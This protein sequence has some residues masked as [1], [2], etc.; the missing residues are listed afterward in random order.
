MLVTASYVTLFALFLYFYIHAAYTEMKPICIIRLLELITGFPLVRENIIF[1]RPGKSQFCSS[2]EREL[3]KVRLGKGGTQEQPLDRHSTGR[4]SFKCYYAA[5]SLSCAGIQRMKSVSFHC[6]AAFNLVGEMR[7]IPPF[8]QQWHVQ[9]GGPT[10][11][12]PPLAIRSWELEVTCA[13]WRTQPTLPPIG[14]QQLRV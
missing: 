13:M 12:Y 10:L 4:L 5:T 9:C 2:F 7:R 3:G 1:S 14:H 8:P 6:W 11:S